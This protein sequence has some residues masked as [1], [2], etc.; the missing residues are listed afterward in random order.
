ME[1]DPQEI[2]VV[3]IGGGMAGL[4]AALVAQ[5][6]GVQALCLEKLREPGG[7]LALSGG[8]LWTI[9]NVDEYLRLAPEGDAALGRMVIEDFETG[10]EWLVEHG[11]ELMEVPAGLGAGRA[12]GGHRI[13]PDPVSGAVMPLMNALRQ[14]G[15]RLETG[16]SCVALGM[17][18]AGQVQSITYRDHSGQHEIECSAVVIATGGFQGDRS[19]VNMHFGRW[20][21][22]AYLRSNDG[23]VGDGIRLAFDAGAAASKGMSAFYGHLFPAPPAQPDPAAFR[24]LTQF[25]SEACILLNTSGQRFVDESRGDEICALRLVHEDQATGFIVFDETRHRNQVSEPYVPDAAH[26]DPLPGIRSVG[27]IVLTADTIP[28]LCQLLM[29]HYGVPRSLA[30]HTI[31]QF[32]DAARHNDPGQLPVSRRSGLHTCENPPFYAVP[33]RPGIT[34]TEG[35]VRVN[36]NCQAVDRNGAVIPGLFVAGADVGAVSV[37]GYIGG[38]ATGLVTGLR[39]GINAAVGPV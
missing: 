34:F 11:V 8:Y 1:P 30:Q 2:D 3:V 29:E 21:D 15:G 37:E 33:V 26:V 31:E 36:T 28:M 23:S 7:S 25:Y 12:F 32:N 9:N 39:A 14:A 38:L 5:E 17:G 13:K 19:L 22:R 35:G 24:T 20:A 27:G 10:V 6:S 16:A 4:T 18:N